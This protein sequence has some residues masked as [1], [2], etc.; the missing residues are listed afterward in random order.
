M[1]SVDATPSLADSNQPS[2][3]EIE[4]WLVRQ[5]AELADAPAET[6]DVREPFDSFGLASRDAVSLS[7]DLEEWLGRT[8]SPTLI[9]EHPTIEALARHLAGIPD[10][11]PPA[12]QPAT[13]PAVAGEPGGEQIAIVGL[14]CRFPGAD[15]PDAFWALLRDGVDA[16]REAPA[17]RWDLGELYDP[18]PGRPGK[19]ATRWGGFLEQIDRFDAPFF[20]ISPREAARMDPQQRLLLEVTWEALEQARRTGVFVGISSSDYAMLQYGDRAAV[21]AYAGTGNAAS[22]A[23]NRI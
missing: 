11:P 6:I 12:A 9:Y 1:L 23:A 14:G 19:L 8:L 7:G 5:I 17:D 20:G 13:A 21:D 3:A 10:A 2:Q 18:R 22:I 4:A 15:G 16:V